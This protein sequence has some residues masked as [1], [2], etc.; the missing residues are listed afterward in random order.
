MTQTFTPPVTR[1]LPS[2]LP[3]TR[4]VALALFRHVRGVDQAVT[5]WKMPDGSY[6]TDQQPQQLSNPDPLRHDNDAETPVFTYYGGHTYQVSD[7]EAALLSAAGFSA[8][9]SAALPDPNP[10]NPTFGAVPAGY[11]GTTPAG[12]GPLNRYTNSYTLDYA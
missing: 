4:G 6:R 3:D 7:A 12:A 11:G 10:G 8:N 1:R 9:L 5:V 2:V